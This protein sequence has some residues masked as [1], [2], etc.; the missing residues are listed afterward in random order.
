MQIVL[1]YKRLNDLLNY[2][3]FNMK[4]FELNLIQN[5]YIY[6]NLFRIF[7]AKKFLFF[8]YSI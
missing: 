1:V 7:L 6:K 3:K 2:K 5:Y 8:N 4:I